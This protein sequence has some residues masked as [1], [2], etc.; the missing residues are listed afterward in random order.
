MPRPR[1]CR[2]ITG[3]PRVTYF[4]PQGVPMREL[5]EVYLPYEG[6]EALRL[7]DLE[8]LNQE[9]AARRMHISRH[10]FGRILA[11]ARR[12]V[13]EALIH[14]LALRIQGGDY[15]IAGCCHA[16]AGWISGCMAETDF[17]DNTTDRPVQRD[18]EYDMSKIAVSSE[19]PT[20]DDRVDPRFG[21]A[22]GFVVVDLDTMETRYIDNGQSQ[23]MS[24]G[25]GI[26]A[27][28]LVARAGV[29]CL[30]TGQVG[31]KAF[32]SLSAAGIKIG[33]K[34]EGLTVRQAVERFKSGEVQIAEGPTRGGGGGG[35]R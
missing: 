22:A 15:V 16:A 9:E 26:H 35:W 25:A 30:L 14:G 27:A 19:G 7:A 5:D 33:Q 6:H 8:G 21:R 20:L 32:Q 11:E 3:E 2:R 29:S 18:K 17:P 10:T 4:K 24:Q 23:A 34:L 28:E 12:S 1:K 31:P 13:A